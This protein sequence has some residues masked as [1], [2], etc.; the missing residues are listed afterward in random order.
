MIHILKCHI[1][2]LLKKDLP[3]KGKLVEYVKLGGNSYHGFTYNILED[4]P[5]YEK[6]CLTI[7]GYA[8]QEVY[9]ND[10]KVLLN[11]QI[12]YLQ[13]LLNWNKRHPKEPFHLSSFPSLIAALKKG[14]SKF[15]IIL[16]QKI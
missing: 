16:L 15:N 1:H 7:I 12:S 14:V 3:I 4:K 9:K 11:C 13:A 6:K 10:E 8:I 5:A 2:R